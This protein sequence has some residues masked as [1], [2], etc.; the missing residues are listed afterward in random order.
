LAIKSSGCA[1]TS[2]MHVSRK[3]WRSESFFRAVPTRVAALFAHSC[4]DWRPHAQMIFPSVC[5]AGA[6]APIPVRAHV[7]ESPGGVFHRAGF[8]LDRQ[9]FASAWRVPSVFITELKWP[10]V[11]DAGF[12]AVRVRAVPPVRRAARSSAAVE[13]LV[14]AACS[15]RAVARRPASEWM[16]AAEPAPARRRAHAPPASA[17]LRPARHARFW[18]APRRCPCGLQRPPNTAQSSPWPNSESRPRRASRSACDCAGAWR[19]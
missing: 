18:R 3:C 11:G 1:F 8:E 2:L 10:A 13:S 5:D 12:A 9:L 19:R 7:D 17:R 16:G 4:R 6:R 15:A 14:H